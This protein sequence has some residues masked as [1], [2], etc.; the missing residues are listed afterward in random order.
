MSNT[1]LIFK[2]VHDKKAQQKGPYLL[3]HGLKYAA[4]MPLENR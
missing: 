2:V 4:P 1:Q 3:V